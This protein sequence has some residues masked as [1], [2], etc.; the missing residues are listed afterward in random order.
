MSTETQQEPVGLLYTEDFLFSLHDLPWAPKGRF[1]QLL[2]KEGE[3]C[4]DEGGAVKNE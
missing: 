4:T 1:K 2:I 3:K